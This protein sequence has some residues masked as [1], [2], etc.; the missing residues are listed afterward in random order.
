MAFFFS[1][2]YL[3]FFLIYFF[4]VE[5]ILFVFFFYF[6][7]IFDAFNNEPTNNNNKYQ[8]ARDT[9]EPEFDLSDCELK[10]VPSGVFILCRVL[11]KE[12]LDLSHNKLRSLN[13]GGSILDL[14]LLHSLDLRFNRFKKLP[15]DICKLT[16]LRV[17]FIIIFF[18]FKI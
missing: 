11:R 7:Y 10:D 2:N 15:D 16:N 4:L 17:S 5:F 8:K 18:L 12:S 9:P 6:C 13:G 3:L 1:T 14:N